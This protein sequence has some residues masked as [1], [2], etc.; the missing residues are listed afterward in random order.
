MKKGFYYYLLTII[1]LVAGILRLRPLLL[2]PFPLNDGGLF[3]Q[4]VVDLQANGYHLPQFTTYNSLQ[5][6]YAY[7]PLTFY[8][9]AW[10]NDLSGIDLFAI[11]HF[12]PFVF[13]VA[14]IPA[15]CLFIEELTGNRKIALLATFFWSMALPSYQWQIMGGGLSRS[16][17]LFFSFLCL[18][19]LLK[20]FKQGKPIHMV[21]TVIFAVSTLLSHYEIFWAVAICMAVFWL[22]QDNRK[23]NFFR[24]LVITI[25]T[26]V[27]VLPYWYYLFSI[28]GIDPIMSSLGSGEFGL[29]QSIIG[30]T[31]FNYSYEYSFTMIS[32]LGFLG[33]FM[34]VMNKK[35]QLPALL[36]GLA[37]LDPRSAN[38]STLLPLAILAADAFFTIIGPAFND[39]SKNIAE[40]TNNRIKKLF[41]NENI[42]LFVILFF[43]S[44]N[45]I[46]ANY[47]DS[48]NTIALSKQ[49]YADFQWIKENTPDQSRFLLVTSAKGWQQDY[50]AEWFPVIADR[51]S[52]N[53]V[54][55]SEWLGNQ[56]YQ[57]SADAYNQGKG[58]LYQDSDCVQTWISTYNQSVDYI[59]V[60]QSMCHDAIP[61][62]TNGLTNDLIKDGYQ[63]VYSS[64]HAYI[65]D[66]NS[67]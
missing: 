18:L 39:I 44:V 33:L 38:R 41:S 52:V 64:D 34:C 58:C 19:F 60:T 13:S 42:I 32:A 37:F 30:L 66:A 3:F 20:S 54:Q 22:F 2:S 65:F 14:T 49:E 28:H 11:F 43:V 15:V 55:G 48:L 50:V 16:P 10:I 56:S 8:L 45:A 31:L 1:I 67:R 63:I 21:L 53:T 25:C 23:T 59:F 35:Y 29:V 9:A 4:M 57:S 5:I 17:A 46:Y 7:P 47:G 6:P 40:P 26:T 51:R 36:L 12:L 27:I 24:L 62:C 61:F